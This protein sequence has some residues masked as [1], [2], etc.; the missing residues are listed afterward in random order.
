MHTYMFSPSGT[1]T[2]KKVHRHIFLLGIQP[3][4]DSK[5]HQQIDSGLLN[6][7][8]IGLTLVSHKGALN[9][10]TI[11]SG[12]HLH[13]NPMSNQQCHQWPLVHNIP[14]IHFAQYVN[15]FHRYILVL[16]N[17]G[18]IHCLKPIQI[19][20]FIAATLAFKNME[21]S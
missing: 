1:R 3:M 4:Q 9:F 8:N 5:N 7:R 17:K 19:I 2:Y 10:L 11:L 15:S 6:N 13:L 14:L 18:A 21:Y 20:H 16:T 12:N